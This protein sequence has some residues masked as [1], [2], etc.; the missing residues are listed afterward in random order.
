MPKNI[1]TTWLLMI[2]LSLSFIG[3]AS[4]TDSLR[5]EN[6]GK[7]SLQ[8]VYSNPDSAQWYAREAIRLCNSL[9]QSYLLG[10]S[11][12]YLGIYYDVVGEF[13]SALNAYDRAALEARNTNNSTTL[14]AAYNNIG[15]LYWNNADLVKASNYFFKSSHIYDSLGNRKGLANT[16]SNIALIFEEQRRP[17]DAL[18]YTRKALSIRKEI[19]DSN[20]L[21]RSYSNLGLLLGELGELDS[22]IYYQRL[23]VPYFVAKNDNYGLSFCYQNFATDFHLSKLLDSA[24]EYAYKALELRKAIGNKKL[25]AASESLTGNV[26]YSM[27]RYE[28]SIVHFRN[29]EALYTALD[30]QVELWKTYRRLANS[31]ENLGD[32]KSALEAFRKRVVISDTVHE[33][34]KVK[35]L[36]E[37]EAKFETQ[38]AEQELVKANNKLLKQAQQRQ[39]MWFLIL[40]ILVVFILVVVLIYGRIELVKADKKRELLEQKLQISR[41]LHDSVGSQLTYVNQKLR[42]I[43]ID[44]ENAETMQDLLSFSQKAISDLRSAIWGMS[45]ML[46]VEDLATKLA[47]VVASAQSENLRVQYVRDVTQDQISASLAVNLLRIG[48]EAI[49]NAVK[50]SGASEIW[51]RLRFADGQFRLEITDNGTWKPSAGTGYGLYFME[52]RVKLIDARLEINQ[53]EKGTSLRVTNMANDLE[54]DTDANINF[55]L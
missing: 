11:Y 26:L 18:K 53:G 27:K 47:E 16:Y 44:G 14:A 2:L 41:D 7:R 31:Y 38:L 45:K 43:P 8:V 10:K 15:L 19:R 42:S 17:M 29:T 9:N 20:N 39:R 13:D 6:L 33:R 1:L 12:N 34:Q 48:Q 21:G 28:E 55:E 49:Q 35:A 25:I 52:E 5:I 36:Y 30:N 4:T 51:V 32:Y 3:N 37:A 40:I 54:V 50:H 23:A 22:S 24:L 46:T